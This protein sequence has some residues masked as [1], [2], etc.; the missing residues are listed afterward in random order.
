MSVKEGQ[1]QINKKCLSMNINLNIIN[2][3]LILTFTPD[4]SNDAIFPENQSPPVIL[5]NESISYIRV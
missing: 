3:F 5:I 2:V 1:N 4:V